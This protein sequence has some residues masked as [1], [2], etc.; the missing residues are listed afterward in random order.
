MFTVFFLAYVSNWLLGLL[1][2]WFQRKVE[3]VK[4]EPVTVRGF[5][6]EIFPVVR[7]T[8]Y[9]LW[10]AQAGVARSEGGRDVFL[11]S[12]QGVNPL[13]VENLVRD[14]LRVD[15]QGRIS[16]P[17]DEVA[18]RLAKSLHGEIMA[19][20]RSSLDVMENTDPGLVAGSVSYADRHGEP[21]AR[22]V[23]SL[24]NPESVMQQAF[25][26]FP[27]LRDVVEFV[28]DAW[29]TEFAPEP[30]TTDSDEARLREEAAEFERRFHS[31]LDDDLNKLMYEAVFEAEKILGLRDRRGRKFPKGWQRVPVGPYTCEWCLMLASRGPVYRSDTV[32][33]S[34]SQKTDGSFHNNCDCVGVPVYTDMD[35][36]VQPFE[37]KEIVDKAIRAYN[38]ETRVRDGYRTLVLSPHDSRSLR[39]QLE[40]DYPELAKVFDYKRALDRINAA[41]RRQSG[42]GYGSAWWSD[43]WAE[44]EKQNKQ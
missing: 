35:G 23:A 12:M 26:E 20:V 39:E 42:S 21:V 43:R 24:S 17:V 30:V 33:L 27:Q 2:W 6:R 28:G 10:W 16:S 37:G 7:A 25:S 19:C 3:S 34:D 32:V 11:A 8:A 13:R 38:S 1:F 22:L 40:K 41:K 31:T 36:S 9:T 5:S 29:Q 15:S 4:S 44:F 14:A 18:Q